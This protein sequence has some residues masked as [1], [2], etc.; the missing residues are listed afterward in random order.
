MLKILPGILIGLTVHEFSH[1]FASY[2]LGDFTAKEDGRLTLN[3]LKHIDPLGFL[4]IVIAGFG[5]AK[6]V[7]FRPENLRKPKR[8]EIIISLAGPFSNLI[9]AAVFFSLSRLLYLFPFFYS[10]E[11]GLFIVNMVLAW[12]YVNL[13]LFVFNLIPIPP[14]DGSHLYTTFLREKNEKLFTY[15]YRYGSLALLAIILIERRTEIDIL[16]FG[17]VIKAIGDGFMKILQ[18]N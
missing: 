11:T 1:A 6:P 18:F 12:G 16:P 3:P 9:L 4:F 5:W 2:R 15:V 17:V 10:Q 8:D 7:M 14:L 13:G